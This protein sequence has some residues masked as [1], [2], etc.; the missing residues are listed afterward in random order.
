[1]KLPFL[2]FSLIAYGCTVGPNYKPPKDEISDQWT[3]EVKDT[4]TTQD[5]LID[6]WNVFN[7]P[8]LSKYIEMGSRHNFN[9][10]AAE[11][12]ILYARALRQVAA[13]AFFPQIGADLNA[14]KT[15]FSKNGPIF[16]IGPSIGTAPGTVSPS[17]GL[18]F[19]LQIPQKQNLYNALFDA[20]WEIDLFGKTRRTVEAAKAN[21]GSAIEQRNDTLLTVLAEI[22]RNYMEVRSNQKNAL[23]I[24]ENIK[25]LEQN[26]EVIRASFT[27]GY[28]DKL[29]LETIEAELA[30]A[31]SAL[32]N[33]LAQMY[34]NIYAISLLTGQ[35]PETLVDELLAAR[36]MPQLPKD[37]AIGVRS[38]LLRRRPDVR[39]AERQLAAATANVGVAVASFFPVFTLL[40]DAGLQSL[41]FKKLFWASSNTWAYAGDMTMPVFQGGKLVGNLRAS[42]ATASIAA[43]SYQQ[44]V[45]NALENAESAI[46]SY[47]E[48]LKTTQHLQQAADRTAVL[49]ELTKD[50]FEKGLVPI[51]NLLDAHRTYIAAEQSLLTSQTAALVDLVA[52]YKS[53]GGGWQP[54]PEENA[55][56][57]I[58]Q[59]TTEI[60]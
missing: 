18:P 50:Q 11:A 7:D 33:V 13:S 34:Q 57:L 14:T 39:Y 20:T 31:R 2:F 37:V 6:W 8:L 19:V 51:I 28:V 26:A 15:Y 45:L 60:D 24:E 56:P 54:V 41:L 49:L 52:L 42:K 27:N 47:S 12:N 21:I 35:V 46:V 53:L 22:A 48:D 10:L 38:D 16:A 9:I 25:V 5:P 4:L 17:T 23:F 43:Y 29:N 55:E 32:P 44:V 59:E 30:N 36:S 1:M 40:G 3:G 58:V